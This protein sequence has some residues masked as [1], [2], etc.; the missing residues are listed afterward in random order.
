MKKKL[1]ILNFY[2]LF[3]TFLFLLIGGAVFGQTTIN[4]NTPP[5]GFDY[6]EQFPATIDFVEGGKSVRFH[7]NNAATTTDPF[8]MGNFTMDY[9]GASWALSVMS[10]LPNDKLIISLPDQSPFSLN[11]FRISGFMGFDIYV[12]AYNGSTLVASL[13]ALPAASLNSMTTINTVTQNAN[14]GNV[15]RVEITGKKG[16]TGGLYNYFD[17]VVIG[18]AVVPI[19]VPTVSTMA[20]TNV[21][22]NTAT[23]NGMV[24]A[25]GA[26]TTVTFNLHVNSANVNNGEG[27]QWSANAVNAGSG[28]TAVS[29]NVTSIY[30][31]NTYYYRVN[32]T[33]SAGTTRG[34]ILSFTTPPPSPSQPSAATVSTTGFTVNWTGANGAASYLLDVATDGAFNNKLPLYND[35]VVN[36]LSQLV[37]GLSANTPYYFRVRGVNSG[38]TGPNSGTGTQRTLAAVVPP[39]I[40]N[41]DGDIVALSGGSISLDLGA[42]ATV[43][44]DELSA[45]NGGL[46]NWAGSSLTVQRSITAISSDV[47]SFNNPGAGFTIDGN[48]LKSGSINFATFTNNNGLLYINFLNDATTDL[49][50][51]VIRSIKYENS[52]P[53]G[54]ATIRFSLSDGIST[55]VADVNVTSNDIYVTN[56]ID[57]ATIDLNDGVSFSEAVAISNNQ[58]GIQTLILSSAFTG[59]MN[60]AGNLAINESLTLNAD[61]TSNL[62]ISNHIITQAGSTSLTLSKSN[63]T[64][65]ISSALAGS[66]NLRKMGE[67]TLALTNSSNSTGMSGMIDVVGGVLNISGY[68][69]LSSGTLT[70][71]GGG[72]FVGSVGTIIDNNITLGV[73]GGFIQFPAAVTLSGVISGGGAFAKMGGGALTLSGTNTNSGPVTVNNGSLN[74]SSDANL[75]T[76]TLILNGGTLGITSN[77][78][79]DNSITF[80]GNSVISTTANATISGVI[81]GAG[82]LTK[83]GANTLTLTGI[84][85]HTGNVLIS[86]GSL[87]ISGGNSIGDNS[88]VDLASGATLTLSGGSETI[89]SLA[90]A[91]N[92]VLGYSLTTGNN[93]T[94]TTFSGVISSLNT[95]GITK[96]GSGTFT[97]SGA[98]TYTGSTNI[99]GGTLILNGGL[100][101]A[102]A[103]V[104]NVVSGAILALGANE[105]LA[106]LA[107][108]GSVALGSYTLTT[109]GNNLSTLFSGGLSGNGGSLNKTGTGT[110]TLSGINA[111]TG[112]TSVA[113][114]TLKV[115][116]TL[117]GSSSLTVGSGAILGG[118][119]SIFGTGSINTLTV[120]NG[121]K[122]A[123]GNGPGMLTINGNLSMVSGSALE[124]EINGITAGSLYD[125]VIVNGDVNVSGVSLLASHGYTAGDA[126]PYILVKN[127]G[128]NAITGTFNGLA[129]GAT[130]TAAGNG[131]MLTASYIG[132]DGNDAVFTA[133]AYPRVTSVS[134]DTPNGAFKAGDIISIQVNF[135]A[136]VDVTGT[137]QLK[138]E[139]GTTDRIIDYSGTGSGSGSLTF[140]YTIQTGDSSADLDYFNINAIMLN[141]GTI[142]GNGADAI[143][144]LP[145]PGAVG[146]LGAG[147]NIVI[148]TQAPNAPSV[149]V[150]AAG[151]DSGI[152]GDNITNVT[153]PTF[154]G[155]AEAGATVTLYKDGTIVLGTG[156][157][158]LISGSWSVTASALVTGP[159]TITAKTSDAAGNISA[160]SVGVT[161][162]VDSTAP[163]VPTGIIATAGDRQNVITWDASVSTDVDKYI[164]YAGTTNDPTV[165]V[166]TIPA[167]TLTYTHTGLSNGTSYF[168]RVTSVDLAGNEGLKSDNVGATPK[169]AQTITFAPVA[170]STYGVP[171]FNL[172]ATS[173]SELAVTYVSSNT[174]VATVSGS[175]VTVLT[176]GT[177]TI[178]ASQA[179]NSAYN[180]ATPVTQDLVVNSKP[181]TVTAA[182]KTKVYGEAD[183]ELTYTV[184]PALIGTDEFTGTLERTT[185]EN[186]GN[187]AI[188]QGN[189]SLNSNYAV[190]YVP[191][192]L[193]IT[194]KTVTVTAAAKT[195]VYGE[196]DPELTYTVA[197]A[198]IGTDEFTGTLERTTGENIGNHAIGQGTLALNSN[199]AVTYVPAN[200]SIT[201]KAVTVTAAAKTKVYGETDPELT[202]T[203]A[204]ALI[205]TDEFTGTLERTTG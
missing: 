187:H 37:N 195:K 139:T 41:L 160:G 59:M 122:L 110:L 13:P 67:G 177:T 108:G 91:G 87:S 53:A 132:N 115:D 9:P 83:T 66:G 105:T 116:G 138:L 143:L 6:Q 30:G 61:L 97:L 123:P 131:T 42:N 14:F 185:G 137:P 141:G 191:A 76:G 165:A 89:G 145:V 113:G 2:K 205:G 119:G 135:S 34:N 153:T 200:L 144:T 148:D 19:S 157:A 112:S 198:L 81:S 40:G 136:A 90:G 194:A 169:A 102:D 111:Y 93:N 99:N 21:T 121:G 38:G 80:S 161:V 193:S 68:S 18:A 72:L 184:A 88:L 96:N 44:D 86:A 196:A 166:Q 78:N 182:A 202:Y 17:D 69:H 52:T 152:L 103:S 16:S 178:T 33:N 20:A 36:G 94:G 49:V 82:T 57:V 171:T 12:N 77:T 147:K 142:R 73:N 15:T 167:G 51:N 146:S 201:A 107:G 47:F 190:T 155:I 95:S 179:G 64:I 120:G 10:G 124:V 150:L 176:A 79:I 101:I 32:A 4:F 46:G 180:E 106:S 63:G 149:P 117:N 128:T 84:N 174:D 1:L 35:L 164:I 170:A 181:I 127:N 189:L 25:N 104:V 70:L 197:P 156:I 188:G 203:V 71:N 100:A 75:G 56:A 85:T 163:V 130:L 173:S 159:H 28:N 158:D 48:N 154:T 45:L 62:N 151:S 54:N 39:V 162:N 134:S 43:F 11:S 24:N 118:T 98:N 129:Q 8:D 65:T 192:N 27:S 186:I 7:F 109:G 26:Q 58:T 125:Q 22:T 92:V 175:T 204:P 29:A 50:Q 3:F 60:L 133:P 168:Y 140:R 5:A 74:I 114:G 23:I 126:D 172:T 199:Y 55:T 183:P 31:G